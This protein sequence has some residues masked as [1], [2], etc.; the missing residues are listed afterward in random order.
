MNSREKIT[1]FEHHRRVADQIAEIIITLLSRQEEP[2][3]VSIAGESGSGKSEVSMALRDTLT[4]SAIATML[5]PQDDYFFYAPRANE[6]KRRQDIG[7]VGM[8]EVLLDALDLCIGAI[9]A[10]QPH[11]IKPR[12]VYA[13]DRIIEEAI[14]SEGIQVIIVDGTYTTT[15]GNIDVRVFIDLDYMATREFRWIRAREVQDEFLE[16]VLAIEHEIIGSH[17][18]KADIIINRDFK[19]EIHARSPVFRVEPPMTPSVNTLLPIQPPAVYPA[20]A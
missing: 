5:L 20:P 18:E 12:V 10:R 3:A 4:R 8:N 2:L 17:R 15:L 16:Q 14:S 6:A 1:A 11:I 13:E 19:L 7:W 9:K